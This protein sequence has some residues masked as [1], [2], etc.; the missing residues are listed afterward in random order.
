MNPADGQLYVTGHERLGQ[1]HRGST[2]RFQ[3]VRYTGEPAQIPVTSIRVRRE[4]RP[5]RASPSRSTRS[6]A[7]QARLAT[8]SRPGTTA[9]ASNYGSPE[10]SPSPPRHPRP[11]PPGP[12]RSAHRPGRRQERCSWRSPT[13]SPSTSSTSTSGPT[14]DRPVDLFATVHKPRPAVHRVAPATR[15]KPKT[16]AAHPILADMVAL[17][18]QADPERLHRSPDRRRARVGDGSRRA[19]T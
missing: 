16:I 8:S 5:A 9:T 19:R 11:R 14:P 12:I 10:L 18:A 2:A 15:P 1:L 4:R 3:R 6:V 13:S 17:T 7:E